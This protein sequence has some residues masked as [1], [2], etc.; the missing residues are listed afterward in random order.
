M[1]TMCD[2]L[3]RYHTVDQNVL[4]NIDRKPRAF[5]YTLMS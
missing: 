2:G 5:S 3:R 4:L 1:K